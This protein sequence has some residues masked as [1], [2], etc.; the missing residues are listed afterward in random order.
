MSRYHDKQEK[1]AKT[2]K[3]VHLLAGPL[4][5]I[6]PDSW[7]REAGGV[8][9]RD[10]DFSPLVMVWCMI[11]QAIFPD[12][13]CGAVLAWLS[14]AR[15]AVGLDLL[16]S[17]TGGYCSARKRL[18]TEVFPKLAMRVASALTEDRKAGDLWCNRRVLVAD[19]SSFSMP[20]TPE[21]QASFP[22]PSS[23]KPGCGFP[24]AGFVAVV[25]L[26]TGALIN[27]YVTACNVHD[28]AMFYYVRCSFIAGDI[29][30]GDRGFAS[31]AE[32][33]LFK[34]RGV[35]SVLRLHQRR[36]TDFR[37]GRILGVCDHIVMWKK[38][39]G[40]PKGVREEDWN[41]LPDTMQIR[42]VRY[43]VSIKG[44]RTKSVTLSTTLLD[45]KEY[46]LEKLSDLYF[47]RW[48]IEV[49]FRHIKE[50]LKMDILRGKSPNVVLKE[51]W[52]HIL[53]YNLLRRLMWEAGIRKGVFA[54]TI[55]IKGAVNHLLG[56]WCFFGLGEMDKGFADLL[57][58]IGRE[59][60]VD[61]PGRLE[62][63][64]KKRR[65][66]SYSNLTEPR[67]ELKKKLPKYHY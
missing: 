67:S 39:R 13:T 58:V 65:D 25:C 35:D 9:E 49:D 10:A 12:Q 20:D 7:V 45:A 54:L 27:A 57:E 48:D 60:I 43:S 44:Y 51:F 17:H 1:Q 29:F 42:E 33:A 16:S 2:D 62:P 18:D 40:R 53:V 5:R 59:I 55:S 30:L 21:N 19:G 37:R 31:Y 66:K 15:S 63:R 50:T 6:L 47:H 38:P 36:K 11:R 61:R 22:Q 56:R 32:M 23:Q 28:L 41:R 64:V 3:L 8:G 52:A 26:A 14:A 46:S 4:R 34:A 24:M